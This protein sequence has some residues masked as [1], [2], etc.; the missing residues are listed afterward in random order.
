V[1]VEM[2]SAEETWRRGEAIARVVK[3]AAR[4][5]ITTMPMED[6]VI[7]VGFCIELSG[8][9]DPVRCML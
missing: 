1:E 2:R 4:H 3:S 8:S 5:T 6:M 9:L 7:Y